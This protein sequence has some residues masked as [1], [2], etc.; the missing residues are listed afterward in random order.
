[1]KYK[2]KMAN[3]INCS[4]KEVSI[5][6]IMLQKIYTYIDFIRTLTLNKL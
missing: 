6:N 1:M 3:K 5:E 2:N 4:N